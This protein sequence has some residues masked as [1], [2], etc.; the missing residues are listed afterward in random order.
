MSKLQ[1]KASPRAVLI[2]RN[3]GPKDKPR[4]EGQERGEW[5]VRA[6]HGCHLKFHFPDL[7][8]SHVKFT[9]RVLVEWRLANTDRGHR[10][11]RQSRGA[12]TATAAELIWK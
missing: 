5:N 8:R 9:P 2:K 3:H 6:H 11:Q 1:A 4:E 10:Q 12:A 7:Y